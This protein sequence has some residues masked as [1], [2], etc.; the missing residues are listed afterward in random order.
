MFHFSALD[1]VHYLV[2]ARSLLIFYLML[3]FLFF[4]RGDD[5][6]EESDVRKFPIVEEVF[7]TFH[8]DC[9]TKWL[10]TFCSAVLIER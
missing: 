5:D 1:V 9:V 10:S 6:D 8:S 7:K 3:R 4:Y 2:E